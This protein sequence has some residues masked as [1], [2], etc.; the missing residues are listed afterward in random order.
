MGLGCLLCFAADVG[1]VEPFCSVPIPLLAGIMQ[2]RSAP[3]S[4]AG[5]EAQGYR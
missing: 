1:T 5:G 3:A 2:Q 4:A